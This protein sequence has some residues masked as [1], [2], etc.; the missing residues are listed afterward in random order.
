[1]T[2][3]PRSLSGRPGALRCSGESDRKKGGRP[4]LAAQS[5][6]ADIGRMRWFFRSLVAFAILWVVYILSPYV[7]LYSFAKAAQ[8]RDA[9]AIGERVDFPAVRISLAKQLAAAYLRATGADKTATSG[10]LTAS[11]GAA[12]LDPLIAAYLTPQA[13]IDLFAGQGPSASAAVPRFELPFDPADISFE[14]LKQLFLV[15]E[16]RGF[17]VFM[18]AL[19]YQNP[20]DERFR[21][22]MRLTGPGEGFT[23]R[24]VGLDLPDSVKDRVVAELIKRGTS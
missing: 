22:L 7:A 14:R 15:S 9:T 4:A 17:R 6:N 20:P 3:R 13:M 21:L 5:A 23:W 16:M 12:L 11:A 10:S 18:V 1:L 24:V 2:I 19:P 8:A